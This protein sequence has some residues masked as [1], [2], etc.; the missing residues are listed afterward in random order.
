[1]NRTTYL[2]LIGIGFITVSFFLKLPYVE[3]V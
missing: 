2:I 1:M 3:V